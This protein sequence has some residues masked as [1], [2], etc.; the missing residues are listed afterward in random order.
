MLHAG[1]GD[2]SLDGGDT[3]DDPETE[4]VDESKMDH[5]IVSYAGITADTNDTTEGRQGIELAS[6]DNIINVEQIVG[7]S[8][9]DTISITDP[10]TPEDNYTLRRVDGGGGADTLNGNATRRDMLV[11]GAGADTIN[12]RGGGDTPATGFEKDM[13]DLLVGGQGDDTLTGTN[14]STDVFAVHAGG[15][16]DVINMFQLSM[17]DATTENTDPD[18]LHFVNL[19]GGASAYD[20]NRAADPNV[21]VCDLPNDQTITINVV[22]VFS[23]DPLDLAKELKIDFAQD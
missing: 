19:A 3:P 1:V 8:L 15:G 12:G 11:G 21:V 9:D 5:D 10:A 7:S 14:D 16:D 4:D 23:T 17:Q 6:T 13:A 2:T 20:C 22:G 18:H